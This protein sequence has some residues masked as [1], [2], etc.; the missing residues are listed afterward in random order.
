M[1]IAVVNY[2]MGNIKSVENAFK[3]IGAEVRVTSDPKVIDNSDGIVLP[4]VGAFKDAAKNLK[5]LNLLQTVRENAG[6]KLFLGI[7][8]GMQLLFE[9]SMEDGKSEG[10]GIFKGIAEKIPAGV[11]IP[12]MGWNQINITNRRSGIFSGIDSGENFYFVHSYHVV[13][14]NKNII[15]SVTDYGAEIVSSIEHENIYGVQ[16]HPEKSSSR[17]L[18]LLGNFWNMIGGRK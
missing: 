11:K 2:N 10:L 18:V 13:P 15:S 3:K 9:Y 17:G 1:Y 8:L 4:G 6:K 7:C 12:H 14:K 5:N 16:F